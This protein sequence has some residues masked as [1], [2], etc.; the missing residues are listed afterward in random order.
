MLVLGII[1]IIVG[2]CVGFFVPRYG[3]QGYGGWGY[4]PGA[5][6]VVIGAILVILAL[7][8]IVL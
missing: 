4:G 3:P 6:L 1:L 7:L 5:L 2:I 8:G